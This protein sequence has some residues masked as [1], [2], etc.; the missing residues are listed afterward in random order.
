MFH[1]RIKELAFK[2]SISPR[3]RQSLS[4]YRYTT[5]LTFSFTIAC[6]IVPLLLCVV[7]LHLC[8]LSFLLPNGSFP[9]VNYSRWIFSFCQLFKMDIFILS[10]FQDGTF[11]FV[12]FQDGS[13]P[14][15]NFLNGLSHLYT[16]RILSNSRLELM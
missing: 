8:R 14:F 7:N 13:F 16:D 9:L 4:T 3:A 5:I 1:A 11:P 10:T 2:L 6:Y 12:N 15:V